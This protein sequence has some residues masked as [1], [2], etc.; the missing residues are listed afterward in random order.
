M[1]AFILTWIHVN[2]VFC[3]V[4]VFSYCMLSEFMTL[5]FCKS[6]FFFSCRKPKKK[7]AWQ[8][9]PVTGDKWLRYENLSATSTHRKWDL[10]KITNYS[11]SA[12]IHR[13]LV[14]WWS[15]S[16]MLH[17]HNFQHRDWMW[18]TGL[19]SCLGCSKQRCPWIIWE[20]YIHFIV[21]VL[22]KQWRISVGGKNRSFRSFILVL[23]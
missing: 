18:G 10:R 21:F 8:Q 16:L 5:G 2:R 4:F 17:R 6:W 9:F 20:N 12:V 11:E 13:E 15:F 22:F 14:P 7:K 23:H 19:L 1:F 3:I